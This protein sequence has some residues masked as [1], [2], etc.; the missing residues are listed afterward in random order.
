MAR[1]IKVGLIGEDPSDTLAI[2]NLLSKEYDL[3]FKSLIRR[4]TGSNLDSIPK[5]ARMLSSELEGGHYDLLIFI[6]DL[7]AFETD[8]AKIKTLHSWF[9]KLKA[10]FEGTSLLLLNIYELEALIIADIAAFNRIFK[11]NISYKS[12][13]MLQKE[14][15]ELLMRK[16]GKCRRKFRESDNP[17]IFQELSFDEVKG[18]CR[19]FRDFIR[20]FNE[21]IAS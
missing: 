12:D 15:K 4:Q 14:P 9:H 21:A 3:E 5:T 8:K 17:E 13:P 18:R 16:T 1:L 7:D 19:Y 6:R 10:N 11:L 20:D 2:R